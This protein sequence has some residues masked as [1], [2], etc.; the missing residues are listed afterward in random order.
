M[1]WGG[2]GHFSSAPTLRFIV[3]SDDDNLTVSSYA[4]VVS[5]LI[6]FKKLAQKYLIADDNV[7]Q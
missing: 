3:S 1:L 5:N 2:N 6:F 4:S 7:L